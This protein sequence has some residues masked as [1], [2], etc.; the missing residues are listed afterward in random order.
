MYP[1]GGIYQLKIYANPGGS[2]IGLN[3]GVG[4]ND[5]IKILSIDSWCGFIP[6][7]DDNLFGAD[8]LNMSSTVG[9]PNIPLG[10]STGYIGTG[11]WNMFQGTSVTSMNN[12]GS[13]DISGLNFIDWGSGG[14]PGSGINLTPSNY[15]S[16]LIG[17]ASLGSSLQV[18]TYFDAGT[19]QYNNIPAVVSARNYLITVKGWTIIDGGVI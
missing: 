3:F 2:M 14:G 12:V 13:W 15:N 8:N 10:I 6:S 16:L 18:G 5:E 17:W 9:V 19:S 4:S 11:L 7:E 1:S